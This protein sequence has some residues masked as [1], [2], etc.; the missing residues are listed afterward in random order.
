MMITLIL[1]LS[2]VG[3]YGLYN[4]SSRAELPN[5]TLELWLR[6][7]SFLKPAG[8]ILLL[9]SLVLT[10]INNGLAAGILFWFVIISTIAS[11]VILLCPL[12]IMNYKT[13][14]LIFIGVIIAEN[15]IL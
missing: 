12:K 8:L 14:V 15:L 1:L 6:K 4:T 11:L 7:Q 9:A 5:G 2:F 10:I 3:F 13:V